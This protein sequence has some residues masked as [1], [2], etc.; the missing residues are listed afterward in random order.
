MLDH[1]GDEG[2]EPLVGHLLVVEGRQQQHPGAADLAGV[3]GEGDGVADRAGAGPRQELVGADPVLDMGVDHPVPLVEGEGIGF[4]RRAENGEAARPFGKER[5]A[6]P[7]E[8]RLVD[9]AVGPEG[10][11][12]GW[13]ES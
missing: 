6:V 7:D 2:V 1:R 11:G 4:A 9:R 12:D 3:A 5:P 10:C 8:P 13:P